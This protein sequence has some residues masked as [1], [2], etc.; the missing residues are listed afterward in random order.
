MTS[1]TTAIRL[2]LL[3]PALLLAG[4]NM[5]PRYVRPAPAVPPALPQG[6]GVYPAAPVAATEDLA[7]I[8]WRDFFQD[9]R[10]RQVIEL[11][12]ANNQDLRLAAKEAVLV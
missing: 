10:L 7:R 2:S 11:G 6:E 12:L 4:C 8:G 5:A 9:E 3:T 1:V